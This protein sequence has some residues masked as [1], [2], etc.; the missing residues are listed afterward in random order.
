MS[1]QCTLSGMCSLFGAKTLLRELIEGGNE[2]VCAVKEAV[3]CDVGVVMVLAY[4]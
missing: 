4:R 3:V 2:C 1:Q